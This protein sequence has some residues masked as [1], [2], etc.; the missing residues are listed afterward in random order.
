VALWL[1]GLGACIG[2]YYARRAAAKEDAIGQY[3][4]DVGEVATLIRQALF[5]PSTLNAF[6]LSGFDDTLIQPDAAV[7][8]NQAA[9]LSYFSDT[10]ADVWRF[11]MLRGPEER[12]AWEA[13]MSAALN[14][15]V[16]VVDP[17]NA[18]APAPQRAQHLVLEVSLV[19]DDAVNAASTSGRV[20]GFDALTGRARDILKAMLETPSYYFSEPPAV[21]SRTGERVMGVGRPIWTPNAYSG[22]S[23]PEA[24]DN[25]SL[26]SLNVHA[27]GMPT[28]ETLGRTTLLPPQVNHRLASNVSGMMWTIVAEASLFKVVGGALTGQFVGIGG[29]RTSGDLRGRLDAL[30]LEDVTNLPE[31]AAL[32]PAAGYPVTLLQ[33]AKR[34]PDGFPVGSGIPFLAATHKLRFPEAGGCFNIN[35]SLAFRQVNAGDV[36]TLTPQAQELRSTGAI[37]TLRLMA[38]AS[39]V[40]SVVYP[41]ANCEASAEV[42][43]DNRH[44]SSWVVGWGGR[45]LLM[46][47]V[48]TPGYVAGQ[49]AS[50]NG[51][52][53]VSIV[54]TTLVALVL[55]F[56]VFLLYLRP[57]ARSL[58]Q[59]QQKAA[60]ARARQ[61]LQ[62]QMMAMLSHEVRCRRVVRGVCVGG[63]AC[64]WVCVCVCGCM[65]AREMADAGF[66]WESG[67]SR[68]LVASIRFHQL[69]DEGSGGAHDTLCSCCNCWLRLFTCIPLNAIK[70]CSLCR[71]ATQPTSSRA[72]VSSCGRSW[73]CLRGTRCWRI[74]TPFSTPRTQ[75]TASSQ[76]RHPRAICRLHASLCVYCTAAR[77][78][79]L[80]SS[81]VTVLATL[82]LFAAPA[83]HGSISL[84]QT[85]SACGPSMRASWSCAGAWS[86]SG[87]CSL[88]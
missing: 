82:F 76:V 46:S 16:F 50:D 37:D 21:D 19:A 34:A 87:A 78:A 8:R 38:N 53:A 51:M 73:R 14:K 31:A 10:A 58:L 71:S 85:S 23:T 28:A 64:G 77:A 35:N 12:A 81:V 43:T 62:E 33:P 1:G 80:S 40:P 57:H 26:A 60:M 65:Q 54:V 48:T 6:L 9:A 49:M 20:T 61:D 22:V 39:A 83:P 41:S 52:G 17:S 88:P 7:F 15:T 79:E 55:Y 44:R 59:S 30:V 56:A 4:S 42:T 47:T 29:Y 45:L 27:S 68:T 3:E 13:K 67:A 74:W 2:T 70:C 69:C 36:R 63:G 72:A 25:L 32:T 18:T 24:A 5:L 66:A 75:C 11:R 84:S 86:T